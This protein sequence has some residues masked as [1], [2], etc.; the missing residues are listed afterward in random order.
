[1]PNSGGPPPP[2]PHGVKP[3]YTSSNA[4]PP[5]R[6]SKPGVSAPAGGA[7]RGAL[8]ASI[9]NR[10][11]PKVTPSAQPSA[12]NNGPTL[13]VTQ[14]QM[15]RGGG[16]PPPVPGG[17]GNRTNLLSQ[18]RSGGAAAVATPPPLPGSKPKP[19]GTTL[20]CDAC[21]H[22]TVRFHSFILAARLLRGVLSFDVSPK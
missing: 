13:Y 8:L 17:T 20:D 12:P 22:G 1:M 3:G 21:M 15:S 6:G 9:Q 19:S 5:P 14:E 2:P 10:A 18:I 16:G 7:G 11:S 4:P